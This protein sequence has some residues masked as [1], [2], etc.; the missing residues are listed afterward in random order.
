MKFLGASTGFVCEL[1]LR[2]RGG[3][4]T[5]RDRGAGRLGQGASV[6]RRRDVESGSCEGCVCACACVHVCPCVCLCVYVSVCV[7][8]FGDLEKPCAEFR[9]KN[10]IVAVE[11]E[12]PM[13]ILAAQT[14]PRR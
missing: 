13:A 2:G 12:T 9:V 4:G 7:C 1:E 6:V 10:K 11:L 14:V 3:G 8:V 5:E